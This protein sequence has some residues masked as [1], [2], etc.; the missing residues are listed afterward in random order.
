[1]LHLIC[2]KIASGKSTLTQQL[3]QGPQAVLISED[4]WLA[5]LYPGQIQALGDYVRCTGLLRDALTA[6]I[7]SLLKAG[8]SVVLDFP[9]NTL[10]S[11]R[12]MRSL[13]EGAGVDHQLHYLDVP[14]A[15]C[16][17]RLRARNAAG[18]HAFETSDAQF[19]LI[20]GY[21]EAPRVEE[22]FSVIRYE[23]SQN[24]VG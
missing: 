6:H 21:F 9:A 11:R 3:S 18:T 10:A 12:W 20:T 2:G 15:V 13:F 17:A 23:A 16:K 4:E 1:M 19:D 5:R 22:G 14:D 8:V 7:I 24:N